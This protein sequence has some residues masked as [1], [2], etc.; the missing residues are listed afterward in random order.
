VL[1]LV[2]LDEKR[3]SRSAWK[4]S[5]SGYSSG[6]GPAPT[7]LDGATV[8]RWADLTDAQPRGTTRHL[9]A[10][11]ELGPFAALAIASYEGKPGYYL[12]YC[13]PSWTVQTDTFHESVE[14]ATQQAAYEYSSIEFI[15]V[16]EA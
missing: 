4:A 14:A 8:L 12:F 9:E 7:K 3:V 2:T 16:P 11:E 5:K 6:V 13:D 1:D 10:D 15:A